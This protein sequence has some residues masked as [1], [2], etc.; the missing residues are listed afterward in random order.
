MRS[1]FLPPSVRRGR[2]SGRLSTPREAP[3]SS[4]AKRE[5]CGNLQ[6]PNSVNVW[7]I[8]QHNAMR[9]EASAPLLGAAG[10][11]GLLR[12]R[13]RVSRFGLAMGDGG[14]GNAPAFQST[15][16]VRAARNCGDLSLCAADLELV[17]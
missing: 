7:V 6:C 9:I 14:Q 12:S 11:D 16:P 3:F 15:D 1:A 10:R 13:A 5:P 4:L 17:G 8:G 2:W